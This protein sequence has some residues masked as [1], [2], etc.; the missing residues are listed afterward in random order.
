[1]RLSDIGVNLNFAPVVDLLTNS[2]CEVTGDRSFGS[3]IDE[4]SKFV[5]ASIRGC[6]K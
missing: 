5:S 2:K 6:K 3:D 4:V 1:M